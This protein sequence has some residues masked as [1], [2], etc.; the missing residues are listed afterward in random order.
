MP[1]GSATTARHQGAL[2]AH[3]RFGPL[4]ARYVPASSYRRPEAGHWKLAATDLEYEVTRVK[5][6]VLGRDLNPL[7]R[8]DGTYYANGGNAALSASVAIRWAKPSFVGERAFGFGNDVNNQ[9]GA[10]GGMSPG[11]GEDWWQKPPE[12]RP[13]DERV[14]S[15]GYARLDSPPDPNDEDKPLI[16]TAM[17]ERKCVDRAPWVC[18]REGVNYFCCGDGC[19]KDMALSFAKELHL[20]CLDMQT[21]RYECGVYVAE[22]PRTLGEAKHGP[23]DYWGVVLAFD[24]ESTPRTELIACLCGRRRG[25]GGLTLAEV[26]GCLLQSMIGFS[27]WCHGRAKYGPRGEEREPTCEDGCWEEFQDRMGDN[28]KASTILQECLASCLQQVCTGDM[29][30][31]PATYEGAIE[32][33]ELCMATTPPP[34]L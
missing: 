8:G 2:S 21:G 12:Y 11:L 1:Q 3:N 18:V 6:P 19:T 29:S 4:S 15:G 23:F 27:R 22:L 7:G 25:W 9:C 31:I 16:Y 33:F 13:W 26:E 20:T 24:C 14:P 32:W 28:W 10:G 30:D 34:L 5:S 17:I